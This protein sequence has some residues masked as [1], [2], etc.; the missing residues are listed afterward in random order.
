MIVFRICQAD[1]RIRS[2]RRSEYTFSAASTG[3]RP[4]KLQ[5]VTRIVIDSGLM[6]TAT[7]FAVFCSQVASGNSNYITTAAVSDY[8]HAQVNHLTYH[9]VAYWTSRT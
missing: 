7:S 9:Y 2:L 8:N 6:Y 3:Q 5:D 1:R 4:T